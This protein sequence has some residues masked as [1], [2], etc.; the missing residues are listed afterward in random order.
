MV[1]GLVTHRIPASRGP[2]RV[3]GVV[4]SGLGLLLVA[5]VRTSPVGWIFLLPGGLLLLVGMQPR[6]TATEAIV[7]DDLGL[8]DRTMD[9]GPIPW[10]EIV[11]AEVG[12]IKRFPVV[13]LQLTRPD[14]WLARM[15]ER[16]RKLVALGAAELGLPPVF[17]YA[18]ALDHPAEEIVAAI[19]QR[20][21]GKA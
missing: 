17:L 11:R 19:N 6:R 18:V 8:S 15:P 3:A 5:M 9:L 14:Q 16:H 12:Q 21:R 13:A 4:L 7:L 20:A 10:D 1:N 2:L